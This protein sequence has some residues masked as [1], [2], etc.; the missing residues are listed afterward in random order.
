MSSYEQNDMTPLIR[1]QALALSAPIVCFILVAIVAVS[2][3][4]QHFKYWFVTVVS[5]AIVAVSAVIQFRRF[6]RLR[7]ELQRHTFPKAS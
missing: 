2:Q 5:A 3:Y 4:H 1:N 7:R 6:L